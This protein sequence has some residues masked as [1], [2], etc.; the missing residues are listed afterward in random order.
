MARYTVR[1]PRLPREAADPGVRAAAEALARETRA[2][3]PHR[4]GRLRAGWRVVP[5]RP[6]KYKVVND[7]EYATHVEFGTRRANGSSQPAVAM[8]GRTVA[9]MRG[10]YGRRRQ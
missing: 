9:G 3:T 5:V 6:G 1:N 4:T 2:V 8:L 7:V 10:R